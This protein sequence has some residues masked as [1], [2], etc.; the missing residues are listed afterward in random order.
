MGSGGGSLAALP[1]PLPV[2]L[3]QVHSALVS[4]IVKTCV[5]TKYTNSVP[6]STNALCPSPLPHYAHCLRRPTVSGGPLPHYA[7]CLRRPTAT[8][9][10]LSQEAHCHTTPTVSGGPLPHYAHCLRRPTANACQLQHLTGI[11]VLCSS[12]CA[13]EFNH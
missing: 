13:Q 12:Y 5:H 4:D 3:Q 11:R 7:H 10:P 1:A 6:Y 9:H 2:W 8:L